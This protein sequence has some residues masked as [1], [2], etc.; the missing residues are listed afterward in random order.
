MTFRQRALNQ[1]LKDAVERSNLNS[2][3][4]D[5]NGTAFKK[6]IDD[7]GDTADELFGPQKDEIIKLANEFDAVRFKVEVVK[8]LL[9]SIENLNPNASFLD[10]MKEL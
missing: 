5:F 2:V 8:M 3:S 7:L 4:K 10:N 1:F 9:G 6:A